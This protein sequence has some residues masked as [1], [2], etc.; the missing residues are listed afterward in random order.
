MFLIRIWQFIAQKYFNFGDFP[1]LSLDSLVQSASQWLKELLKEALF[2]DS[3]RHKN[4]VVPS[5]NVT[6]R[7]KG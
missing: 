6:K 1:F 7:G 2:K 4:N 5:D 3:I